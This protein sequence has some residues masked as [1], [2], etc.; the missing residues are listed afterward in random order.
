MRKCTILS[1]D[2]M[3]NIKDEVKRNPN[4]LPDL[5]ELVKDKDL[6]VRAAVAKNPNTPPETLKKLAEEVRANNH[7]TLLEILAKLAKE[8]GVA[9]AKILNPI[10]KVFQKLTKEDEDNDGLSAAKN[11][12]RDS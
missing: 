2:K 4:T 5:K 12:R 1:G 7:N 3:Y 11:A 10:K 9:V 8:V 6:D